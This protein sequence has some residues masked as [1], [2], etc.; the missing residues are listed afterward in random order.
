VAIV[1]L[2]NVF[3]SERDASSL[4]SALIPSIALLLISA[5][6]FASAAF[7]FSSAAF[8]SAGVCLAS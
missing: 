5:A 4:S 8:L 7:F 6:S 3:I 1:Y 2:K